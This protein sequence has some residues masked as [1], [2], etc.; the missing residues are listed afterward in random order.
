MKRRL[1]LSKARVL[2][3]GGGS[4]L[5]RQL[6]LQSAQLGATVII[7]D[8]DKS[9]AERVAVEITKAGG[10]ATAQAVDVSNRSAIAKAAPLAGKVDVLI[11]N[12]GVVSGDWFE[13]ISPEAIERTYRVNVLPLYWMTQTFLPQMREQN[14]GCVVTIASAAGLIGVAK[15]T[16]YS[17]SKFAAVGFTE[18]LRAELRSAHSTVN[19]LTVCPFYIDTGMFEGV[20]TRFPLLLPILKQEV[21]A[22]KI[23]RGI[24]RGKAQLV[25]PPFAR[26]T[27]LMRILP[28]RAFDKVADFLGVNKTM[29]HFRG[30]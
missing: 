11:N 16:D 17:A 23:L 22:A 1:D 24:Q 21:V 14:Y 10:V 13:N 8:L 28:V 4:G 7:W 29:E 6:A 3:T 12:A 30:R 15:Q 26:M 25:L 19:T 2:I 5:G 27:P 9:A 20:Q 18:S